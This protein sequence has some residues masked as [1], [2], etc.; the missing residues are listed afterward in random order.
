MAF[1]RLAHLR[2]IDSVGVVDLRSLA[3]S[4]YDYLPLSFSLALY[5]FTA[6]GKVDRQNR[7]KFSQFI[8][9]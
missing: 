1:W 6:S 5:L 2:R 3:R 8:Y 9:L 7:E 4:R